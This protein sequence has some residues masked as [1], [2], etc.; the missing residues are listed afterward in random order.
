VHSAEVIIDN[1]VCA[2]NLWR[3]RVLPKEI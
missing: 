2:V 3:R 1:H